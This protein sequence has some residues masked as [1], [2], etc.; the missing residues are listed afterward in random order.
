MK[1][2]VVETWR[3]TYSVRLGQFRLDF[4]GT[5]ARADEIAAYLKRSINRSG[6]KK[7]SLTAASRFDTL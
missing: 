5:K 2:N 1:V 6:T 4:E 3:H 7:K